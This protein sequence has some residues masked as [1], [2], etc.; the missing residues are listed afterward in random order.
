MADAIRQY[1]DQILKATYGEEVRMAIANAI[2]ECYQLVADP[3]NNIEVTLATKFGRIRRLTSSERID[4]LGTPGNQ[5]CYYT[6]WGNT[7]PQDSP[8]KPGPYTLFV[9][10]NKCYNVQLA[11]YNDGD[12]FLR[13]LYRTASESEAAS[14]PDLSFDNMNIEWIKLGETDTELETAGKP[15]D[16]KAVG[17]RFAAVESDVDIN[18][19]DIAS[20]QANMTRLDAIENNI[21]ENTEAIDTIQTDISSVTNL[22]KQKKFVKSVNTDSEDNHK[23]VVNTYEI[24]NDGSAV[25]AEPI[26]ISVATPADITTLQSSITNLFNILGDEN[27]GL[28]KQINSNTSR[29]GALEESAT[30]S[31][32]VEDIS[33]SNNNLIVS[34]SD[35]SP[36][37]KIKLDPGGIT[38]TVVTSVTE[39]T[40][41]G[42]AKGIEVRTTD[43]DPEFIS[44]GPASAFIGTAKIIRVTTVTSDALRGTDFSLQYKFIATDS[45]GDPAGNGTAHLY[46]ND[47]ERTQATALNGNDKTN[48]ILI[49][50]YLQDG[51][52]NILVKVEVDIG[53]TLVTV[54][55]TWTITLVAMGLVW[56]YSESTI[57]PYGADYLLRWTPYG[58]AIKTTHFKINGTVVPELEHVT[59]KSGRTMAK[60]I[61]ANYFNLGRNSMELWCTAT[62]EVNGVATNVESEHV[63][64]EMIFSSIDLN[65][66]VVASSFQDATLTQ[67]DTID[68]KY[69]VYDFM[70]PEL[71]VELSVDGTVI[72][73]TENVNRDIQTWSYSPQSAGEKRLVITAKNGSG[74]RGTREITINVQPLSVDVDEVEDYAFKLKAAELANNG[75]LQAWRSNGV[76]LTLSDGFDFV[77]GGMMETAPD[78]YH[79]TVKFI[80]VKAGNRLT[81]NYKLFSRNAMISGKHFKIIFRTLS[82]K[83]FTAPW[84]KCYED[85]TSNGSTRRVGIDLNANGGTITSLDQSITE[86]FR[87]G[88][89]ADAYDSNGNPI[90]FDKQ[91]TELEYEINP[92]SGYPYM[93]TYI[94]GVHSNVAVYTSGSD[95]FDNESNIIIGSDECDVDIYLV[96]AYEFALTFDQHIDNFIADATTASEMVARYNRND[97]RGLGTTPYDRIDYTKLANRNPDLRVHLFDIPKMTEA[98]DDKVGGCTYR[99][100]YVGGRTSDQ[101][102]ADNVEIKIQGTSSVEYRDSAANIDAKFKSGFVHT[103]TGESTSVYSMTDES[104]G[105]NYFNVKVNVASCENV[106][107]MCLA[108]WYDRFQPYKTKWRRKTHNGKRARDCMEH[109]MG[110]QFIR[111][112]NTDPNYRMMFGATPTDLSPNDYYHMYAICN[113]GNSK[114]NTAVFHDAENEYEYCVE[115]LA[116]AVECEMKFTKDQLNNINSYMKWDGNVLKVRMDTSSE[117]TKAFEVRHPDLDDGSP[118]ALKTSFTNFILWMASLNPTTATGELL[119]QPETYAPYTFK[120]VSEF[121]SEYPADDEIL[122]GL[123]INTYAGT[124]DRDTRERRIAKM[125]SEC[126]DHFIMDA[127]V[128]HYIFLEQHAM[129]DNVCKNSFWGTEDGVHWQLCKNYDN[130]TADGNDNSGVINIPT[131]AEGLDTRSVGGQQ[132]SVF[133]G[134]DTPWWQFVYALPLARARV[135]SELEKSDAWNVDAYLEYCRDEQRKVPEIVWN[136][137]YWY[138]YLRL[139]ET[140]GNS[141]YI[142]KLA[143]GTKNQQRDL[144]VHNQGMYTSSEYVGKT[145]TGSFMQIFSGGTAGQAS[146]VKITPYLSGYINIDKNQTQIVHAKVSAGEETSIS[147]GV[148]ANNDYVYVRGFDNIQVMDGIKTAN[149]Q[150][151]L[152]VPKAPRLSEFVLGDRLNDYNHS[153]ASSYNSLLETLT[154]TDAPVL[155]NAY[156]QYCGSLTTSPDFSKMPS[157][158]VLDAR[159]SAI[160]DVTF[161]TNGVVSDIYLEAPSG[162][163]MTGL[164][165]LQEANLHIANKAAIKNLEINDCPNID[166]LAF[167]H[168]IIDTVEGITVTGLNWNVPLNKFRFDNKNEPNLFDKISEK[169]SGNI[170]TSDAANDRAILKGEATLSSQ[171]IVYTDRLD[172]YNRIWPELNIITDPTSVRTRWLATFYWGDSEDSEVETLVLRI[173]DGKSI[174]ETT[175]ELDRLND[176]L[177]DGVPQKNDTRTHTYEFNGWA[178]SI[179]GYTFDTAFD[180]N[181]SFSPTFEEIPKT[182]T[183]TWKYMDN[184]GTMKVLDTFGPDSSNKNKYPYGF[185]ALPKDRQGNIITPNPVITNNGR[186]VRLFKGWNNSTGYVTDNITVTAEYEP[187]TYGTQGQTDMCD[188]NAAQIYGI[189]KGYKD[190]RIPVGNFENPEGYFKDGD[191]IDIDLGLDYDFNNIDSEDISD[192]CKYYDHNRYTTNAVLL[193]EEFDTFTMM[194][195]YSAISSSDEKNSDGTIFECG[196]NFK[197]YK[198]E[199]AIKMDFGDVTHT[200]PASGATVSGARSILVLRL[201]A[202]RNVGTSDGRKLYWYWGGTSSA[203]SYYMDVIN[204]TATASTIPIRNGNRLIFGGFTGY[205]YKAKVWHG[206]LGDTACKELANWTHETIRMAYAGRDRYLLASDNS[207]KAAASFYAFGLLDG[208]HRMNSTATNTGGWPATE[209]RTFLNDRVYKAFPYHWR[210][211]LKQV[212]VKSEDGH[213][214]IGD[215]PIF[216]SSEDY[217]YLPSIAEFAINTTDPYVIGES[218]ALNPDENVYTV[219]FARMQARRKR[220]PYISLTGNTPSYTTIADARNNIGD[221]HVGDIVIIGSN[222]YICGNIPYLESR[223]INLSTKMVYKLSDELGLFS[224]SSQYYTSRTPSYAIS[225][226]A[227]DAQFMYIGNPSG[228]ANAYPAEGMHWICIGFSI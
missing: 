76:S 30:T 72:A 160:S 26:E 185:E 125:L 193:N 178:P 158:K 191:W 96:K 45:N 212:V 78:K 37:K 207:K 101:L 202:D 156:L 65:A 223:G 187:G 173:P 28:I 164:R 166:S 215:D 165:Q 104:I 111:C 159:D 19:A 116:N 122:K 97:V 49:S 224:D 220:F 31:T 56:D 171:I 60:S 150:Q 211:A 52:N 71:T 179:D 18:S 182:F 82:S 44:F 136:Q 54:T 170:Q 83:S 5:G 89:S 199:N 168:S 17:D 32:G 21:A 57:N 62:I 130:D 139:Y 180:Q 42:G 138:K 109:H 218:D 47:I 29:I 98:K 140:E 77:N 86:Y 163:H 25:E 155:T 3:N 183:V 74:S 135:W 142:S 22:V 103:S 55:K 200:I 105:V 210:Q 43:G 151:I 41:S 190:G 123:T 40:D 169:N 24:K 175:S 92:A 192:A 53:G 188:M 124:Y 209:M 90:S 132:V 91:Y 88:K 9:F 148:L 39:V 23:I 7:I 217:I 189:C 127:V 10:G 102:S 20:I 100:I 73:T 226:I 115:T 80:R 107:N 204:R 152:T 137:D 134:I 14:L 112:R 208:G 120:G 222:S 162:L 99:Q 34:Y 59:L 161:A 66:P 143:C 64:H 27:S 79:R 213:N 38:E 11:M 198:E 227:T 221:I 126:E 181:V 228:S 184:D 108:E 167:V 8:K 157:L 61:S 147:L 63:Y 13:S 216:V 133:N 141:F 219:P 128:Y 113:M 197:L 118:E 33:K 67:Y 87:E 196:S 149:P 131:G 146:V 110:V 145:N 194:I 81:I 85:V 50:N 12:I 225:T 36:S 2:I 129:V 6:P 51:V 195:E 84:L 186:S 176:K 172:E 203:R 117:W 4:L 144:F 16:A 75:A 153:K 94:N 58:D 114:K 35:G 205:I 93:S 206:D 1:T 119:A 177:D 174:N 46:V 48:D 214:S 154:F 69:A 68:I 70:F 121:D 15:A 106:N 201:N 95:S